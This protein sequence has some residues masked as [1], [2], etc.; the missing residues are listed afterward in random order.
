MELGE[1]GDQKR[2]FIKLPRHHHRPHHEELESEKNSDIQPENNDIKHQQ[3]YYYFF[4]SSLPCEFVDV[5]YDSNLMAETT[6]KDDTSLPTQLKLFKAVVGKAIEKNKL[7]FIIDERIKTIMKTLDNIILQQIQPI[8]QEIESIKCAIP[9]SEDEQ[10]SLQQKYKLSNWKLQQYC[11]PFMKDAP[12]DDDPIITQFRP[13]EGQLELSETNIK[14]IDRARGAILNNYC[15]HINT[16]PLPI[17]RYLIETKGCNINTQDKNNNTPIHDALECFNLDEGGDINTLI[18]LLSQKYISTYLKGY[19]GRTIVHEAFYHIN[20]LP[21]DVFK[22]LI[23]KRGCNINIKDD[24][25]DIPLHEAFHQFDP[26]KGGDINTLIYLLNQKYTSA[27]FKG[28]R[29]RT[30]LNK[31]LCHINHLPLDVFKLL[32]ETKGVNV[33]DCDKEGNTPLHSLIRDLSAF[34]T[35]DSRASQIAEYLIQKEVKI[36]RKNLRGKT[37]LDVFSSRSST[38]PLT[39]EVLINNGA[40][41][42]RS[43]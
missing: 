41:L 11:Q 30:L 21:L 32:I 33:N 25:D 5:L 23:D 1:F 39:Y 26:K 4:D 16:T 2:K 28:Y 34:S 36:N 10:Q 24:N 18:Y 19:N 22:Y 29:D 27:N 6:I 35:I 40:K 9:L 20:H 37:V 43:C 38:H 13:V 7:D 8:K 42:G 14:H 12:L 17:F 15:Q 3:Q 31:A